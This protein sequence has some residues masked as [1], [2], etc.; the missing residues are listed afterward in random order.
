MQL[1]KINESGTGWRRNIK[2]ATIYRL[3]LGKLMLV[4]LDF[5]SVSINLRLTAIQAREIYS[6]MLRNQQNTCL[7]RRAI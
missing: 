7:V 2:I 1:A 4:A 6:S 3:M 5:V